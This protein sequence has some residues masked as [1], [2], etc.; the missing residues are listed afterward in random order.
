MLSFLAKAF[1]ASFSCLFALCQANVNAQV[2]PRGQV[3]VPMASPKKSY[4][5]P[6]EEVKFS[7]SKLKDDSITATMTVITEERQPGNPFK[8]INAQDYKKIIIVIKAFK[9]EM[10]C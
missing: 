10:V 7:K 9:F 2:T 1:K 4:N 6:P 8:Y 5:P 3:Q